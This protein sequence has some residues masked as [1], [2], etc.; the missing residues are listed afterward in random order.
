MDLLEQVQMRPRSSE[1]WSYEEKLRR[2]GLFSLEK[3]ALVWPN[4]GLPVSERSYKKDEERLFIRVWS[5][6]KGGMA[7]K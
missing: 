4:C 2:S 6:R 5:D 7:S 1:G 3:K